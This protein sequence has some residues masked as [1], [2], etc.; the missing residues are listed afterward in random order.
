M[1]RKLWLTWWQISSRIFLVMSFT[2]ISHHFWW[3]G[4]RPFQS[5]TSYFDIL[6]AKYIIETAIISGSHCRHKVVSKE[7]LIKFHAFWTTCSFGVFPLLFRHFAY[8]I[9]NRYGWSI[10]RSNFIVFKSILSI[11]I[12]SSFGSSPNDIIFWLVSMVDAFLIISLHFFGVSSYCF[13]YIF[14]IHLI[15]SLH[16]INFINTH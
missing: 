1:Y 9:R 12:T 7:S 16:L 11:V 13:F 4:T 14:C 5:T 3:S 8:S 15:T 10:W 2:N 6:H